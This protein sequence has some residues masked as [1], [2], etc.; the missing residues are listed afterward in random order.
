MP[1]IKETTPVVP[2]LMPQKGALESDRLPISSS[3]SPTVHR[4]G[5]LRH[6]LTVMMSKQDEPGKVSTVQYYLPD[7]TSVLWSILFS[8]RHHHRKRPS[9]NGMDKEYKTCSWWPPSEEGDDQDYYKNSSKSSG[10]WIP[11]PISPAGCCPLESSGN[12]QHST[13]RLPRESWFLGVQGQSHSLWIRGN[14]NRGAAVLE[15]WLFRIIISRDLKSQH[16]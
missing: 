14:R 3:T 8:K 2:Q 16:G 13:L 11:S 4:K 12:Q 9:S 15:E 10:T 7:K 1:Q 6:P 5:D